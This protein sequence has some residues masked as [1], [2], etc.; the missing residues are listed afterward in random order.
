MSGG[1]DRARA[2]PAPEPR[3][4]G[5]ATIRESYDFV[6]VSKNRYGTLILPV[7][8]HIVCVDAYEGAFEPI[9]E[10]GSTR[11]AGLGLPWEALADV[12]D[13]RVTL[14]TWSEWYRHEASGHSPASASW[15]R[16]PA[17]RALG[18]HTPA[19]TVLPRNSARVRQRPIE[20]LVGDIAHVDGKPLN[21]RISGLLEDGDPLLYLSMLVHHDLLALHREDPFDLLVFPMWGGLGYVAQLEAHTGN[22]L[23]QAL[24]VT[25]VVTSTSRSRFE[26]NQEGAWTRPTVARY[27]REELSVALADTVLAFGNHG[28][29]VAQPCRLRSSTP[30]VLAPFSF[31]P[32][33][34]ASLR[35]G[36]EP[37]GA[38]KWRFSLSGPVEGSSGAL[39]LL[40]AARSMP[41]L[42]TPICCDGED[43]TFAPQAPRS[44]RSYWA[45]RGWVKELMEDGMWTWAAEEPSPPLWEI[46]LRIG[47]FAHL[48]DPLPDLAAGK[49]VL[50]SPAAADTLPPGIPDQLLLGAEPQPELV[51]S[52]LTT[53]AA[54]PGGE[55]ARL[56][57]LLCDA[58]V[59]ARTRGDWE[60]RLHGAANALRAAMDNRRP[61]SIAQVLRRQLDPRRPL[62]DVAPAP[63]LDAAVENPT[64]TV[65]VPCYESGA[66]LQ[67][68]VRS[69]WTS[70]RPPD[71]V[72]IVDDGSRGAA[73]AEA[74]AAL[75]RDADSAG[76]A[77]RVI[78]QK[79]RGLAGARNSGIT[80]ASGTYIS[81]LDGDDLIDPSFY[82]L[83]LSLLGR[84]PELGGVSTWMDYFG[85]ASGCWN[86]VQPELPLLLCVNQATCSVLVTRTAL[87]RTLGGFDERQRYNFEDWELGIRYLA[88]GHPIVNIPRYL[89]RYR[90]RGDSLLRTL[91]PAQHQVMRGVTFESHRPLVQSFGTEL[92]LLM[93][94]RHAEHQFAPWKETVATVAGSALGGV[95]RRARQV[96]ARAGARL[97]RIGRG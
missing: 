10:S 31:D 44:F 52:R 60:R 40:D 36:F 75:V 47:A 14:L 45:S 85:E 54:L 43:R 82:H 35:N 64:L 41:T 67:E 37:G 28:L 22:G 21:Q 34:T 8:T 56:R 38:A 96:L 46:R 7:M 83:A 71:E 17:T 70:S 74:L 72:I 77:L 29:G 24:P 65:V 1:H 42:S 53:L 11:A 12:L 86:P 32:D 2:R 78:R 95:A 13:A 3:A 18:K 4:I 39:L 62:A 73:T 79:N 97:R 55:L 69:I 57:S 63:R 92:A 19:R 27:Q 33:A 20:P 50:F 76:L 89:V 84:E 59:T 66:L 87:L 6:A 91:T 9:A 94:Y 88:Q 49:L 80:A 48:A 58:M 51:A 16:F 30:P 81:F 26:A 15:I 25:V 93:E 23:L 90:V 5:Q 61:V 68:T